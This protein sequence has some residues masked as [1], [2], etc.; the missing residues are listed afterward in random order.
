[1]KAL[2][3]I[4]LLLL[5]NL[6]LSAAGIEVKALKVSTTRSEIAF[7]VITNSGEKLIIEFDIN[8]RVEPNLNIVFRFCDK[9]WRPTKNNFFL[10]TGKDIFYSL[11]FSSLPVSV[12]EARYH[13]K[14]SFPDDKGQVSF[15]FSGKWRFYITDSQDTSIVYASGKFFVAMSE[16]S[17]SAS[18]K[19]EELEEKTLF[20]KELAK[21]FNITASLVLPDELFPAFVNR[22]E[23]IENKKIEYPVIVDRTFN[24][25]VRQFYWD[26]S[27]KFIFTA[28]DIQPGNEYRQTDLRNT[29]K[30]NSKNVKAQFDGLEYSRFF[31]QGNKD[32]N[33]GFLLTEP[34]DE[35]AT[36]LNVTFSI[37]PPDDVFGDIF[38]VGAFNNWKL[39]P[40]Y[41]MNNSGGV[42]SKTISLKRGIYDYQY[43][44]ADF[45]NEQIKNDD[46]LILE[47]NSWDTTNEYHIF[48][49]YDDPQFG[50]YER[51]IGYTKI[52]KR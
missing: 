37:R 33:G 14:G 6:A 4:F 13:F 44:L 29:N 52:E 20:P 28:R 49:I 16:V 18:I 34:D 45:I 30:F 42:H 22:I 43:V 9:G 8:S 11:R 47:G 2:F 31:S 36:F 46:W 39:A 26:G 32:L 21:V 38:L 15:P 19:N 48:L 41:R 40:E 1:M 5:N 10:N 3:I 17:L 51:I 27:R 35:Y 12:K 25:N 24:T 50:G 23:I 7:P